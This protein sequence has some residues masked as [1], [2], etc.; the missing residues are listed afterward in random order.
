M[1]FVDSLTSSTTVIISDSRSVAF[2]LS[3]GGFCAHGELCYYN[4]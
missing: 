1:V 4:V 2:L 3:V